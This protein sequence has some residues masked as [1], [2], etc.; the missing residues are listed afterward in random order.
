MNIADTVYF[1]LIHSIMVMGQ[2]LT[3]R[4]STVRRL[5]YYS[6]S[7]TETPLVSLRKTSWKSAL[8]EWEW[9]M[10]G[11]NN[12]RDAHS[13]IHSWWEPW[14]DKDGFVNHNYSLQFREFYGRERTPVD[15]I[16]HLI[17]G[18]QDHPFS[19]RNVITTWNT[20]DM[21]SP[22]CP[23][24]NC[25]GTIIQAFVEPDNSL[26]LLTYQRSVDTICG[27]PHN[28][29]QY[30]AF[31][32]WLAH[33]GNRR[34]G[35]LRWIGGDVHI[36]D[37]HNDLYRRMLEIPYDQYKETPRLIYTPSSRD[38]LAEDFSLQGDYLPILTEKAVMVV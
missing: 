11:S 24:T 29:I 18:I 30:W 25:H 14:A 17:E 4:N 33:R 5:I 26:H 28:W 7:F 15:Q 19:R 6:A 10:S 36:Y 34:V 21:V 37:V 2:T 23:I 38:F 13:S 32:L 8:R 16:D 12:I 20:A 3:T 9:F 1:D 35:S 22:T 31:L 27:L